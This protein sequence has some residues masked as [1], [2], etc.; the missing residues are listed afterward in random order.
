MSS[1][2]AVVA[3]YDGSPSATSAVRW[4]AR[5]ARRRS[6]PLGIVFARDAHDTHLEPTLPGGGEDAQ[7][8]AQGLAQRGRDTAL[9]VEPDLEVEASVEYATPAATLVAASLDATTVVVGSG[10]TGGY[11]A[12][13]VGR[14]RSRWPRTPTAR[15]SWCTGTWRRCVM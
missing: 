11:A 13:S 12:S 4:A 2:G 15:S 14:W 1:V 7:A 8:G 6:T 10:T 3:G 9:E 5:E